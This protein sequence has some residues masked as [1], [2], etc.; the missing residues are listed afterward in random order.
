MREP[1]KREAVMELLFPGWT[2]KIQFLSPND[3][4]SGIKPSVDYAT[5]MPESATQ[6]PSSSVQEDAKKYITYRLPYRESHISYSV[7]IEKVKVTQPFWYKGLAT[8]PDTYILP[9]AVHIGAEYQSKPDNSIYNVIGFQVEGQSI[10]P[11]LKKEERRYERAQDA[12]NSW[13]SPQAYEAAKPKSEF[14]NLVASKSDYDNA[15]VITLEPGV[16]P[17]AHGMNEEGNVPRPPDPPTDLA[18]WQATVKP[19]DTNK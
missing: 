17:D 6:F 15:L 1:K 16:F 18:Q 7:G 13:M 14:R 10:E 3:I 19:L 9:T 8:K 4:T 11:L 12:V 5:N 2:T